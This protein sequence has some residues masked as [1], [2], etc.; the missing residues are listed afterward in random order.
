MQVAQG[1]GYW[2]MEEGAKEKAQKETILHYLLGIIICTYVI[3]I[4][5]YQA[6]FSD[7]GT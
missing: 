4:V 6:H 3:T 2:I 7:P 1:I 5:P